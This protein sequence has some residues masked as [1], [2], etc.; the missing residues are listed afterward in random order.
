M[1]DVTFGRIAHSGIPPEELSVGQNE[2]SVA[3]RGKVQEIPAQ[4]FKHE[5]RFTLASLGKT[6]RSRTY[7]EAFFWL[8]DAQISIPCFTATDPSVGLALSRNTSALK[9]YMADTG[10]LA[11]M[12]LITSNATGEDLYRNV[13]L[14]KI[15]L[16]EGM[17]TENVVAQTLVAKGERLFFYSQSGKKEDEER[18][19]IDFLVIRPFKDASGKA[20]VSPIE[21]KSST[22]FKTVSLDRFT[23]LFQ[24]KIGTEYVIYP[25]AFK[26]DG[27]RLLVPLY[28]AH[29]I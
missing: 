17:L 22:R 23:S 26:K 25:G 1:Q 8:S 7:E 27:R 4:L 15:G 12:A 18:L 9:C 3:T 16:N 11:T 28:A 21:V 29:C 6:A 19:E 2:S 14:G 24:K 20:R 13:F 5:K 10:L